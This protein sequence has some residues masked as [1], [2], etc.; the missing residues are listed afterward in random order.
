[1][2][3]RPLDREEYIEQAY[4]FRAFRERLEDNLPSQEILH[5][6]SEELLATTDL[7]KAIDFL[8][9]EIL[10]NGRLS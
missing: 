10:H 9:G 3:D 7:P 1:M 8:R 5:G 6:L 2:T 4:C